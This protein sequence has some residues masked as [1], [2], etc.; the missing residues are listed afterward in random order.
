MSSNRR[1]F[2]FYVGFGLFAASEHLGVSSLDRLAAAAMRT[3]DDHSAASD[4]PQPP[5]GTPEAQ[6]NASTENAQPVRFEPT[7]NDGN[8]ATEGAHW[9]RDENSQ[10]KWYVREHWRNGEWKVTGITRPVS[11]LTSE[12][13]E[14]SDG[15]LDDN[16]VPKEVRKRA[17][18]RDASSDTY[19]PDGDAEG[20]PSVH[21]RARH[22]RP[23]SEWL[24]SLSAGELHRWLAK[25]SVPEAGVSGMSFWTHLTR[26]HS[27]RAEV[28]DLLTKDDQA[29]L[30]SAAHYGY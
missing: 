28:V 23:P 3:A 8:D 24:R 26:D 20:Q 19:E 12:Q 9:S 30:H 22:G 21:R 11:K 18:W 5:Q 10:W 6:T 7:E 15:Y 4:N 14:V 27:F 1:K 13:Y 29:K 17:A 16:L 2:T 25:T